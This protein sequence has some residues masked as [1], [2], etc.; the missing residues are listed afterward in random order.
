MRLGLGLATFVLVAAIAGGA[1]AQS[2]HWCEPQHAYYPDTI[3]CPAP[4]PEQ[5]AAAFAQGAAAWDA[6]QAWFEAQTGDRRAGADFWAANRSKAVHNS[7]S[8]AGNS[9]S[10]DKTAFTVGCQEAKQKLD[11]IDARRL[12]EPDY[13]AGF[14][15]RAEQL[16]LSLSSS[17]PTQGA[18]QAQ[19][20]STADSFSRY[21]ISGPIYVGPHVAPDLSQPQNYLFRT[22]ISAASQE[23]PNFA[24][25]YVISWWGCGTGCAQ[26]VAVN[27]ATGIVIWLPGSF[28]TEPLEGELFSYRLGSRLLV[29]NGH[30]TEDDDAPYT[31]RCYE[32]DD[33]AYPQLMKRDCLV[34]APDTASKRSEP[35]ATSGGVPSS[36]GPTPTP[37]P[38]DSRT[39]SS[40]ERG[41]S[42]SARPKQDA[43]PT[44]PAQRLAYFQ[45]GAAAG[46][47]NA[48]LELGI[49]YAKGAGVAQDYAASA[50]WFRAAANHGVPRAQYDLGVMYERGRGVKLDL[51]EAANWYLKSAQGGYPLAQ[52][53]IAVCYAKGQG[54][55]QD[56]AEAALWYRRAATRGVIQAMSNLAVMYDKGDGVGASPVDAYAWYRAAGRRGD[57]DSQHRAEYLYNKMEQLDQ[58]HA[59]ALASDVGNSIHEL[60]AEGGDAAPAVA[61]SPVPTESHP[62]SQVP[63]ESHSQVGTEQPKSSFFLLS[64]ENKGRLLKW[65]AIIALG[66]IGLSCFAGFL[67]YRMATQQSPEQVGRRRDNL[68]VVGTQGTVTLPIVNGHGKVRAAGNVWLA[69][70]PNLPEGAEIVI[71]SVEGTRIVVEAANDK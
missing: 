68:P 66:A 34:S 60:P 18:V 70:G 5:S 4:Y 14:N 31:P 44:D 47:A 58:I 55:R 63:A 45:Q 19:G 22:R 21:P 29:V 69:E 3:Q 23:T 1:S 32:L 33:E 2:E 12:S 24:G 15:H 36:A 56:L 59:E 35:V 25:R 43:I 41:S 17:S 52:Y 6:L 28:V 62:A 9:F 27:V 71:K 65:F 61:A 50:N 10:G 40:Q 53:N 46:D 57:Q 16:P 11:P 54:V 67:I 51:T 13:R 39:Q 8:E 38:Q 49:I 37:I 64:A 42:R 7:C 20:P 48:E 30:A 26:G